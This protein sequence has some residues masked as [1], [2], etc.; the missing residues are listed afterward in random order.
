MPNKLVLPKVDLLFT[1]FAGGASG[2]P[3]RIE[4]LT[5]SKKIEI[6][7]ANRLSVLYTHVKNLVTA[8][9]PNYVVPYAGYFTEISRDIEVKKI[10]RKNSPEE[11]VSYVESEFNGIKAIN[12]LTSSHL[13]LYKLIL[14]IYSYL[15]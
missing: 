9:K 5:E 14:Q 13:N 11:L 12:P 3:S 7:E 15:T 2:F 1:A 4:N 8:T 10:N 6:T